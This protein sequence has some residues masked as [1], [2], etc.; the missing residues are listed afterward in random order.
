MK[1]LLN[2]LNFKFLLHII[3]FI[4]VLK[5]N[6]IND[7]I[8]KNFIN[9]IIP[10]IDLKNFDIREKFYECYNPGYDADLIVNFQIQYFF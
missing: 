6:L 8:E 7:S 4:K 3:V 9:D 5:A 1:V 10:D 2:E